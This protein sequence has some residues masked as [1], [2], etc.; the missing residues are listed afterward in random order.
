MNILQEVVRIHVIGTG[1]PR[2]LDHTSDNFY[3]SVVIESRLPTS[4]MISTSS[5]PSVSCAIAACKI[6]AVSLICV[7]GWV[8]VTRMRTRDLN[9][10]ARHR[11]ILEPLRGSY[12][13]VR[14]RIS[15]P[16]RPSGV[17]SG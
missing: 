17:L 9:P 6:W 4:C 10:T 11:V 13:D 16:A 1:V 3:A 15:P 5:M 14:Q 7:Q 8:K 12:V 2:K